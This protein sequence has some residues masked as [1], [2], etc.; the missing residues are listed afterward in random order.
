MRHHLNMMQECSLQSMLVS[1]PGL[2]INIPCRFDSLTPLINKSASLS[3]NSI[4]SCVSLQSCSF[5][6]CFRVILQCSVTCC[7][8]GD[9]K[10]MTK[11]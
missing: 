5:T 11:D 3:I 7:G 10:E 6:V 1:N 9:L 8:S 2:L 4:I